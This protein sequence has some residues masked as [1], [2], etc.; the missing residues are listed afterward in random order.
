[1][2]VATKALTKKEQLRIVIANTLEDLQ[3]ETY[4]NI[5]KTIIN[6]YTNILLKE[7]SIRTDLRRV[8][9]VNGMV[10]VV[11]NVCERLVI[12]LLFCIVVLPEIIYSLLLR[13]WDKLNE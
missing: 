8:K 5:D 7:V 2:V 3:R 11:E 9:E 6:K 1:M 13:T 10:K 12:A 4:N